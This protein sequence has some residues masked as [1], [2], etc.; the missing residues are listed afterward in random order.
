MK[1]RRYAVQAKKKLFNKIVRIIQHIRGIYLD[2]NLYGEY[3]HKKMLSIHIF[4]IHMFL[5]TT[6]M[7]RK[8]RNTYK[9]NILSG[10]FL[11][12]FGDMYTTH[13]GN[14]P[15]FRSTVSPFLL[16]YLPELDGMV[17]RLCCTLPR[18]CCIFFPITLGIFPF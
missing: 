1:R 15:P 17:P 18:F 13:S 5:Y 2:Y 14:R 9:S 4:P 11:Q 16:Y 12:L 10:V 7:G 6:D 8:M 3:I